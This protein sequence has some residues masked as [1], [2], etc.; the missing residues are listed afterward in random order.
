MFALDWLYLRQTESKVNTS[1]Q[2]NSCLEL[3]L[4]LGQQPPAS[5]CHSIGQILAST[6]VHGILISGNGKHNI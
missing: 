3:F 6:T 2:T 1:Y 5:V 4:I